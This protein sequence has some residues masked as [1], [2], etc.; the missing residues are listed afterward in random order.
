MGRK[1]KKTEPGMERPEAA[2]MVSDRRLLKETQPPTAET[3]K[4]VRTIV[5]TS[6]QLAASAFGNADNQWTAAPTAAAAEVGR[7]YLELASAVTDLGERLGYIGPEGKHD[8]ER[9]AP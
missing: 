2:Q 1:G 5:V 8:A 7:G 3:E 6:L 9:P 4:L